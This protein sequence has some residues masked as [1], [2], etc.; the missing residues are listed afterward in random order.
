MI[1]I[2]SVLTHLL[3]NKLCATY[4]YAQIKFEKNWWCH[5][6]KKN[7]KINYAPILFLFG[8]NVV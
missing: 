2:I 8:G 5:Q 4:S 3:P 7:P 6:K 1:T